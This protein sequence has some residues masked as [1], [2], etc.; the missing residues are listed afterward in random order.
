LQSFLK[1][2]YTPSMLIT[3]CPNCRT[4]FKVVPDQ[5]RLGQGWVKCGKCALAFN[6]EKHFVPSG[7]SS[8]TSASPSQITQP[9]ASAP[10]P[11]KTY[12]AP[13]EDQDAFDDD[14]LSPQTLFPSD[15]LDAIDELVAMGAMR[16]AGTSAFGA[17]VP[18]N[19]PPTEEESA[20]ASKPGFMES[21]AL[22]GAST[23]GAASLQTD[24]LTTSVD[25]PSSMPW[26]AAPDF[27]RES[28]T[29]S[30]DEWRKRKAERKAKRPQARLGSIEAAAQQAHAEPPWHPQSTALT[31]EED[32]APREREPSFVAQA[33]S[34][35]RWQSGPA[36]ALLWVLL[37]VGTY[38]AVAQLAY[39]NRHS[40]AVSQPSTMPFLNS[41]CG[42]A[43]TLADAPCDI[44]PLKRIEA[45][46][47]D[48]HSLAPDTAADASPNSYVL[49]VTLKNQLDL[50]NAWP[51]L[52][53]V[54]TDTTGAVQAR[55]VLQARDYLDAARSAQQTKGLAAREEQ[56]V[57]VRFEAP[58]LRVGGYEITAF[59]P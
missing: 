57:S 29:G 39:L 4:A 20:T 28:S 22:A 13:I 37:A 34:R 17:S 42:I 32:I 16:A 10:P 53:I 6:A 9:P 21:H 31:A 43:Q 52:D 51:A 49:T 55:R 18:A 54:F 38:A 59:Y 23:Q 56:R 24:A 58:T 1:L 12:K 48:S 11:P 46:R 19:A 3:R 35:E 30:L 33:K 41:V 26:K 27:N 15:A 7:S 14:K 2:A 47:V 44:E 36:R 25:G 45:L 50:A 8:T 40:L 5:L